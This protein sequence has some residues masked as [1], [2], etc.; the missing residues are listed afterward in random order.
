MVY[1]ER[2]A[3]SGHVPLLLLLAGEL[4]V[5]VVDELHLVGEEFRGGQLEIFLSKVVMLNKMSPGGPGAGVQI[6]AMSATLPN[7][8]QVRGGGGG[9]SA[10]TPTPTPPS[11]FPVPISSLLCLLVLS[12][13]SCL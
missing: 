4:G 3:L 1:A 8:D 13:L 12:C 11:L 10:R 5:V 6:V 2:M 9:V 7:L